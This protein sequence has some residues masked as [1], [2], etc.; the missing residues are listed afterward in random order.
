M[1]FLISDSQTVTKYSLRFL[2]GAH[3]N[4][5]SKVSQA[6]SNRLIDFIVY[7]GPCMESELTIGSEIRDPILAYWVNLTRS[8]LA[9][10]VLQSGICSLNGSTRL[11]FNVQ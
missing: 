7:G 11:T 1:F 6:V 10:C 8:E 2:Q 4:C 9:G 5:A 3:G